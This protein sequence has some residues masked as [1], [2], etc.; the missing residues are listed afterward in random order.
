MNQNRTWLINPNSGYC[1]ATS[2]SANEQPVVQTGCAGEV[3][4]WN[5]ID[6]SGTNRHRIATTYGQ[7]KCLAARGTGESAAVA[8]GCS[9]TYDDQVWQITHRTSDDSYQFRNVNS[10]LC[11]AARGIAQGAPVIQTTC[12][13]W[14]DQWWYL[15]PQ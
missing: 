11:L 2:E 1:M 14:E 12:G 7:V 8:T 10:R 15:A 13:N 5:I 9:E 6:L 3:V 4:D